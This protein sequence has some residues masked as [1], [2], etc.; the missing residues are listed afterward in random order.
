MVSK[1]VGLCD[2][3]ESE[4]PADFGFHGLEP[5]SVRL[6]EPESGIGDQSDRL[7]AMGASRG[8]TSCNHTALLHCKT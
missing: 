7:L 8:V 3:V 5:F 1:A 2:Y 4:S 6:D